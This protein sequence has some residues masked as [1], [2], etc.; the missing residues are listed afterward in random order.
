MDCT[1]AII[2][3]TVYALQQCDMPGVMPV[4]IPTILVTTWLW[5]LS[6][7]K[8]PD[9]YLFRVHGDNDWRWSMHCNTGCSSN[10]NDLPG[11]ITARLCSTMYASCAPIIDTSWVSEWVTSETAQLYITIQPGAHFSLSNFLH[12]LSLRMRRSVTRLRWSCILL[13]R[14]SVEQNPS[15]LF[16]W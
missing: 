16:S 9:L 13:M 7:L 1:C 3:P 2:I 4:R 10:P 5:W 8:L 6:H 12:Y 15:W 14:S 11:I